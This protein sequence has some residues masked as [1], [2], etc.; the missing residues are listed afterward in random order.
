MA[1]GAELQLRCASVCLLAWWRRFQTGTS[2]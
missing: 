2:V 1:L